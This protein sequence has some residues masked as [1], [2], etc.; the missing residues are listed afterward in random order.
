MHTLHITHIWRAGEEGYKETRTP[1][2]VLFVKEVQPASFFPPGLSPQYTS[3]PSSLMCSV[4]L[5][6]LNRPVLVCGLSY[7]QW[8]AVSGE[9]SCPCC[10]TC[11][12]GNQDIREP[13]SAVM[14]ILGS[15]TLTCKTCQQL[16]QAANHLQS[17]CSS[18]VI[19]TSPYEM[20]V[21]D[22]LATPT[23]TPPTAVEWVRS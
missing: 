4:C 22:I 14:E 18:D 13:P 23:V 17:K 9:S 21:G 12:M 2:I 10:Y 6:V 1:Q 5:D 20:T 19:E 16:V 11:K 7:T 8:V 15:L 3:A